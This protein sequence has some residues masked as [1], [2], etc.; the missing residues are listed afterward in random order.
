[1]TVVPNWPAVAWETLP[2]RSRYPQAL[3]ARQRAA[4]PTT[5]RSSI[6]PPIRHSDPVVPAELLAQEAQAIAEV[7]RFNAAVGTT[8]LPWTSLLLRSESSAS[9]RIERLTSSARKV[10]EEEAFGG[11]GGNATAVVANARAMRAATT[12]TADLD[13]PRLL[14]IHHCLMSRTA[15]GI[16]GR[17]RTEPVW[18]GGSDLAPVGALFVPP[19]HTRV[20]DALE[21]LLTFCRRGD[22]PPLTRIAIA[23]AQFETIHP[24]V[25]GNGRT[26]R[27]LIHILLRQAGLSVHAPLPLSAVLLADTPS[28]SRTLDAYRDADLVPV[29]A[30]TI[31]AAQEA[32]RLGTTAGSALAR[33]HDGWTTRLTGRA[34]TPDRAL[35]DLLVS[36]PVL[37]VATAAGELG[38]SAQA[39]RRAFARLEEAGIVVGYQISRGRRAWRA[40][41]ILDL[42]D[43]VTDGLLRALWHLPRSRPYPDHGAMS[44]SVL[45][46]S[47]T[48]TRGPGCGACLDLVELTCC[49]RVHAHFFGLNALHLLKNVGEPDRIEP[50]VGLPREVHKL[51][52]AVRSGTTDR[53]HVEVVTSLTA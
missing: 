32:A 44:A 29:I 7:T 17:L 21:D 42:M 37:D 23:H 16:A 39:A 49:Y 45:L 38:V 12:Q 46:G 19:A 47:S 8:L 15:P 1:M 50:C 40:P 53:I 13:L 48:Y 10:L 33:V 4:Q 43:S 36:R 6:V 35:A 22:L 2:W 20:P 25:N 5:Y 24:F 18:I 26:G 31:R 52:V 9:S 3:T 28:Y 14:E 41:G 51:L 27:A 11:T 30:L 34:G